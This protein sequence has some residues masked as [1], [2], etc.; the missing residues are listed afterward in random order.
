MRCL[1]LLLLTLPLAAQQQP[2]AEPDPVRWEILSA[3][4]KARAGQ[5]LRVTLSARVDE[6]WHM[7]SMKKLEGGPEPLAVT[8]P[9]PQ[10]FRLAGVVDAPVALAQFEERFGMEVEFYLGEVEFAVPVEVVREAKPGKGT[11]TLAV[12]Y[13]ACDNKRCLSPRTVR[14]D[15]VIRIEGQ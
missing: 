11:L 1:A 13:Q 6:P 9:G 12:R 15:A 4:E 2:D 14:L 8:A 10:L 7:H 5:V 3:P